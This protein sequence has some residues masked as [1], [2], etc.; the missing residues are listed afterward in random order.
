MATPST[1]TKR[2]YHKPTLRRYGTINTLTQAVAD[3][4]T[5]S[6]GAGGSDVPN[7]TD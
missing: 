5:N 1:P 4:G 3:F 6:D 7:K 2:D